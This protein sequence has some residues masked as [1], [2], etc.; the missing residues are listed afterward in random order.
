MYTQLRAD[1]EGEM[2]GAATD[3]ELRLL[4]N[5]PFLTYAALVKLPGSK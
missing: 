3:W 2:G 4:R 5:D 1:G